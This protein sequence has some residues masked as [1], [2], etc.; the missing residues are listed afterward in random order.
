MGPPPPPSSA[1]RCP[2][3]SWGTELFGPLLFTEELLAEPLAYDD[4]ALVVPD[5]PGLGVTVDPDRLD[6]LRRDRPRSVH[7]LSVIGG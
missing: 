2:R 5:G 4:F 1:P 7:A 6:F 3:W